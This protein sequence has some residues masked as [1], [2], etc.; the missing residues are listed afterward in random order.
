[1]SKENEVTIGEQIAK[2][3]TL[4]AWFDSDDFNIEVAFDRYKQAEE[5][6]STI[7][8]RL[9]VMKNDITVLARRFDED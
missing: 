5:L 6:A 4:I 2:L 9:T 8:K 1:M 3:D 7:E